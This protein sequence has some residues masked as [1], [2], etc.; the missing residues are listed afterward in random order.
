MIG[1]LSTILA[2]CMGIVLSLLILPVRQSGRLWWAMA[3]GPA[4]GLSLSTSL[5]FFLMILADGQPVWTVLIEG[6]TSLAV[7]CL[8]LP[9][10]WSKSAMDIKE[11]F[12]SI[13][14]VSPTSWILLACLSIA[15]CM[16]LV[17]SLKYHEI[18]PHGWWDAIMIW[19]VRAK[20]FV[21]SSF[22]LPHTFQLDP[23]A[24]GDYPLMLPLSVSRLWNLNGVEDSFDPQLLQFAFFV[25]LILLLVVT[26]SINGRLQTGLLSGLT[27]LSLQ[28]IGE[29][30]SWQIADIP[31]SYFLLATFVS[32]TQS[33]NSNTNSKERYRWLVFAG[34]FAASSAWMK[35][36][37]LI[38]LAF[39]FVVCP[40]FALFKK[41]RAEVISNT[42]SFLMGAAPVLGALLLFKA[43]YAPES[44]LLT[45][46]SESLLSLLTDPHRHKVIWDYVALITNENLI[47]SSIALLSAAVIS[48]ILGSRYQA[49]NVG[50]GLYLIAG[51]SSSYYLAYL[52][53]PH[54]ITW[55]VST[56]I[57]RLMVQL[58]PLIV[59]TAIPSGFP[60]NPSLEPQTQ[61]HLATSPAKTG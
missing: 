3:L 47:L 8:V 35:N 61:R 11:T 37:G 9:R 51:L 20:F 53:T 32:L 50:V 45:T 18:R 22:G 26:S 28:S 2:I 46:R 7:L 14:N 15:T 56:S 12:L 19:N 1:W 55:H 5:L 21:N 16:T 42:T 54:D 34:F 25:P 41:S 40:L 23:I 58:W 59:V 17:E 38:V 4:V 6:L 27:Y 44:D 49:S 36:E 43:F 30:L 57:H 33:L 60:S 10:C 24:H 52:T 13:Q 39:G 48:R 29:Q 31:L